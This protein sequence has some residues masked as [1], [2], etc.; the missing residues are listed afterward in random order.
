[1]KTIGSVVLAKG[2]QRNANSE[3]RRRFIMQSKTA[4]WILW[5][6]TMIIFSVLAVGR[7]F[8]ALLVAIILSSLVWYTVVPRR[9]SRSK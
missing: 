2:E 1:M 5:A 8:D 7:H 9:A 4:Q 3:R 6:I